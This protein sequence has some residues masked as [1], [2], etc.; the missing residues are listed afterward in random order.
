MGKSNRKPKHNIPFRTDSESHQRM[1]DAVAKSNSKSLNAWMNEQLIKAANEVLGQPQLETS[2]VQSKAIRLLI[3]DTHRAGELVDRLDELNLLDIDN[4]PP[5]GVLKFN[6]GLN[7]FLVGLDAIQPFLKSDTAQILVTPEELSQSKGIMHILEDITRT[8]TDEQV[9]IEFLTFFLM[10]ALN[11]SDNNDPQFSKRFTDA[12]NQFLQG[13][14]KITK[15]LKEDKA[16]NAI[17]V[18]RV[19]L[20]MIHEAKA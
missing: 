15:F 5:S 12:L 2:K 20:T 8:S 13:L 14:M 4:W 9:G 6:R 3:E 18:L 16:Q 19:I 7:H 17:K 1:L 10:T 11:T